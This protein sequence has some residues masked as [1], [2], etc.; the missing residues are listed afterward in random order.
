MD[1][2]LGS[3]IHFLYLFVTSDHH[4]C[5]LKR[6]P[7]AARVRREQSAR[8]VTSDQTQ[9]RIQFPESY[10]ELSIPGRLGAP[11]GAALSAHCF[12]PKRNCPS[13]SA[14]SA[15]ESCIL[16][17][18]MSCEYCE[19]QAVAIG[20]WRFFSHVSSWLEAHK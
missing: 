10:V 18:V 4:T 6:A 7:S 9:Q 11:R 19:P 5:A 3:D 1:E 13:A 17:A 12:H 8:P 20:H 15:S 2:G 16:P 14:V